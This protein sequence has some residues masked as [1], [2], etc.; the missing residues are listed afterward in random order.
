MEVVGVII[1]RDEDAIRTG[2][3]ATFGEDADRDAF[4]ARLQID[5]LSAQSAMLLLRQCAVPQM[6][7]L[8]RCMPPPCIEMQ[9]VLFD[10]A[11]AYRGCE[12]P[13]VESLQQLEIWLGQ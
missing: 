11:G 13:R 8:L 1:G 4:F 5:D 9:A 2:I 6:N 12:W 3:D 10:V 7:Y